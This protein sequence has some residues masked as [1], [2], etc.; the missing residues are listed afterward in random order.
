VGQGY[1]IGRPSTLYL[2]AWKSGEKIIVNVGGKVRDVAT[3]TWRV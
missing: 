2:K 3:G 1:E